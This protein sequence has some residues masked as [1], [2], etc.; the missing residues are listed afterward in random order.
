MKDKK[1]IDKFIENEGI[2]KPSFNDINK[3]I[4]YDNLDVNNVSKPNFRKV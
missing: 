1:I 2:N 3:N 4:N